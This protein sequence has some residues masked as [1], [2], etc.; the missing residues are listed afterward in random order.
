MGAVTNFPGGGGLQPTE[1][2]AGLIAALQD[3]LNMAE[4]GQLQSFVGTG[5]TRDGLRAATW[6]D[7]HSDV[8][9]ML[10]ALAWLQAEY[11]HRHTAESGGAQ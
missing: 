1:P 6:A 11:I 3:L 4:T 8:Y 9:Q 7:F 10:G 2:N 5:F